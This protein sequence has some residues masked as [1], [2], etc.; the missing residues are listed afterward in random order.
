MGGCTVKKQTLVIHNYII[1]I[2]S[3]LLYLVSGFCY[4]W[5]AGLNPSWSLTITAVDQDI[6]ASMQSN[7]F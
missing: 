6:M 1:L 5:A 3:I 4:T 7:F 2:S